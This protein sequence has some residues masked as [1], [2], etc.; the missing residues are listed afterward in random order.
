MRHPLKLEVA[1]HCV[2]TQLICSFI[3]TVTCIR[4]NQNPNSVRQNFVLPYTIW[5]LCPNKNGDRYINYSSTTFS[6]NCLPAEK[7]GTR[8]AAMT[9]FS[10]VRGLRPSRS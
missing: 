8:V 7:A 1:A 5:V 2:T 3:A 10:P 4:T 9:I 6:L